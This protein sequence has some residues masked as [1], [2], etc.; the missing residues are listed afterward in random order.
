MLKVASP[1]FSFF[2]FIQER[3]LKIADFG[4]SA[5]FAIA[6][7]NNAHDST[8]SNDAPGCSG[9]LLGS[10]LQSPLHRFRNSQKEPKA[11]LP[12]TSQEINMLYCGKSTASPPPKTGP[13]SPLMTLSDFFTSPARMAMALLTCGEIGGNTYNELM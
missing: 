3:T 13:S 11:F 1:T 5:T 6:S 12:E 8:G 4:L 2:S 7:S 9:A 10:F